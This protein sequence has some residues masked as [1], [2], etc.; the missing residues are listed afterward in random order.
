LNIFFSLSPEYTKKIK[1]EYIKEVRHG[2]DAGYG[3]HC[4]LH[5][6]NGEGRKGKH[7]LDQNLT[8]EEVIRIARSME[9][10]PNIII[11]AGKNAKWYLKRY[12]MEELPAEIEK[13][14]WRDTSK[15]TMYILHPP[16]EKVEPNATV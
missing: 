9:E 16:L 15:C 13:Q 14:Q 5:P 2:V 6:A 10:K 1:M 4:S 7:G 3:I 11:K 12:T 8:L